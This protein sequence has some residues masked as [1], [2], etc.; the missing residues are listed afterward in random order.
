MRKGALFVSFLLV[1]VTLTESQEITPPQTTFKT[2]LLAQA[3]EVSIENLILQLYEHPRLF[4]GFRAIDISK[5]IFKTPVSYAI[6]IIIDPCRG[7]EDNCCDNVFGTPE[8]YNLDT[9]QSYDEFGALMSPTISRRAASNEFFDMTCIVMNKDPKLYDI[10]VTPKPDGAKVFSFRAPVTG[11]PGPD[12]LY[13]VVETLKTDGTSTFDFI[14]N[15]TS[16]TSNFV[17]RRPNDDNPR[18]WDY[19]AS[20]DSSQPCYDVDG[21][22]FPTCMTVGYTQTAYIAECGHYFKTGDVGHFCGTF[23][24]LHLKP[25]KSGVVNTLVLAEQQL[26]G[27]FTSGYRSI[28]MPLTYLGNPTRV[29]CEGDYEIWWTTRTRSNRVLEKRKPFH[30]SFPPCD[31]SDIDDAYVSF[32]DLAKAPLPTVT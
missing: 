16:C 27:G 8:Y 20:V 9:Q 22:E 23:L 30:V 5:Y 17:G 28:P 25:S 21:N 1:L 11:L 14:A 29:V 13:K 3:Y 12:T 6:G 32:F 24:E 4:D 19:N 2:E 10:I 7:K 26:P 31:F 18:C 15:P